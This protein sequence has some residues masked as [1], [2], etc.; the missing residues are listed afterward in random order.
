MIPDLLDWLDHRTGYKEVLSDALY[1]RVP[2]GARW[3]YIWGS[4]LVFTFF[5]QVITGFFLWA[6]YCPSAQTAWES[7]YFIQEVMFLGWLVRGIHH[8]AA[9]LM[10]VL[11]GIHLIQVVV[12]GAYRAPREINFWLGLILMQIVLGL[13]LTGYLLPW[14]QK[15]YYATQV[16]TNIV[17]SAPRRGAPGAAASPRGHLLWTSHVDAFL[18]VAC[19]FTTGAVGRLSRTSCGIL[20]PT[21]LDRS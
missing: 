11:M 1:E 17:G 3:R 2:G 9:Q 8:Y 18:C 21:R 4:T 5:V 12:D 10:I 7:V 14:D 16:A 15:G 13:S 20:P 6:A 19:R